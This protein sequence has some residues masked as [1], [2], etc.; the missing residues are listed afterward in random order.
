MAV[1]PV[2]GRSQQT[3]L[4]TPTDGLWLTIE[5]DFGDVS[6][7]IATDFQVWVGNEPTF[8]SGSY[9]VAVSVTNNTN[10]Q[11]VLNVSPALTGRWVR[12]VVTRVAGATSYTDYS[13]REMR[14]YGD[15]V[16]V[17]E[18]KRVAIAAT[19]SSYFVTHEPIKAFDSLF[20]DFWHPAD[21][22]SLPSPSQPQWVQADLG[23]P[24]VIGRVITYYNGGFA[25]VD[26][27]TKA[28]DFQIWVGNDPA[29]TTG[30]YT[31]AASVTNNDSNAVQVF[32]SQVS[33][34]YVRYVVTRVKGTDPT[35]YWD[36]IM[37][38][39]EMWG[40]SSG[41]PVANNLSVST[42]IDT[43]VNITLVASDPNN[44][45]LTYS[46][47]QS[48]THGNLTGS[49]PTLVYTPASGYIGGDS[50]TYKANDG[51][52]DSNIAT[53]SITVTPPAPLAVVAAVASSTEYNTNPLLKRP[54]NAFDGNPDTYWTMADG[55]WGYSDKW[56]QADLGTTKHLTSVILKWG[57]WGRP[58]HSKEALAQDFQVWVGDDPTFRSGSYTVAASSTNFNDPDNDGIITLPFVSPV[59]GRWVR[60]VV[61][62]VTGTMYWDYALGE[63][64]IYGSG[65]PAAGTRFSAAS[66][67]AKSYS[68][69]QTPSLAF[70]GRYDTF[71]NVAQ[72]DTTSPWWL[73]ADLGS[74]QTLNRLITNYNGGYA[75]VE[76]GTKARDFQI[77]VGDDP[78]F[79]PGNYTVATTVTGNDSWYA[80]VDFTAVTGRY[81]RYVVSA[82]KGT[83]W[84]D[85]I[86][87]ELEMFFLPDTTPPTIVSRSPAPGATGVAL[88]TTISVGFSE[89]MLASSISA[90]TLRLRASGA[91]SDVPATITYAGTTA[92]LTPNATLEPSKQY[93][94]T[95]VG[96]VS[97][98]SSNPMGSDAT[99]N[100]T[101]STARF[102]DTTVNDFMAGTPGSSTYVAQTDDGE[103]ILAPTV[104]AEFYGST[105]PSGWARLE[106]PPSGSSGGTATI[107]GGWVTIDGSRL[108]TND[109]MFTPGRTL[110]FVAT[111]TGGAYQ[112]AGLGQLFTAAPWAA[113]DFGL[114]GTSMV[115]NTS[116][117]TT[118]NIC[119]NCVGVP[120]RYRIDWTASSVT[121]FID[122]VQ[123]ANHGGITS[124][125]RPILADSGVGNN[126]LRVDWVRMTPYAST[127]TFFSLVFDA[128]SSASWDSLTWT[129]VQPAGTSI[130]FATR[131]GSTA[132]PDG[133]WETWKQVNSPIASG[134]GRYL[135]YQV[136]MTTS[137]TTTTPVLQ[138]VTIDYHFQPTS[139]TLS[140]FTARTDEPGNNLVLMLT[141]VLG[142]CVTA[143]AGMRRVRRR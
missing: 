30:S 104:G 69:T 38:E 21:G 102:T 140:S 105:L 2:S 75:G 131:T 120:H 29:F 6:S 58:E 8:T 47:V 85:P 143:I 48:P 14:I 130:A 16:A 78:S 3:I 88:N 63:M 98:L 60:Y 71:W 134:N 55:N 79:A 31:V 18:T 117:T 111:F 94:V 135:Q 76:D 132:T 125:M 127:G 128:G 100:F 7:A 124:N 40:P 41:S 11:P 5:L 17:A 65:V 68:G 101:T 45:P 1:V 12:Y 107:S 141:V 66:A 24:Q 36:A 57:T 23:N 122:A 52:S 67:T 74:R 62:R 70:D 123:V 126:T 84:Y 53:V 86:M 92:T 64:E 37:Y 19:A 35:H 20:N 90:S 113:F 109:P 22:S 33:G 44:D 43:P 139:V 89:P 27:G 110:E 116:G 138:N 46:V 137:D 51:T 115:A 87:Y 42:P 133:S 82:T 26:D 103:V 34:R 91:S 72:S 129:V 118:A 50:F 108:I 99:W 83:A 4:D 54:M 73:Q 96:S 112:A 136:T 28:V 13:V 15:N 77:W 142:S 114:A 32:F 80:L 61:T 9:Q 56:L 93:Q 25:L 95:V 39:L 119:S 97:D 59:N 10:N 121:Y 106:Y 81:V 49:A